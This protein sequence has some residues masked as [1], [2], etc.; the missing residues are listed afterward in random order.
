MPAALIGTLAIPRKK[1]PLMILRQTV[2][3]ARFPWPQQRWP[4][5][6]CM[7]R[8]RNV[9]RDGEV[10]TAGAAATTAPVTIVVDR[11]M[12]KSETD[13]LTGAFKAG[14]PAALRKALVGVQAT[15][16]VQLGAGAATRRLTLERPTDKG[17]LLTIVTDQPLLFRR[18]PAGC[19]A[20][21][22]L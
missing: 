5:R 19:Q 14:G 13:R 22:R 8:G 17:R 4:C 3:T 20:Q 21:R 7:H 18:R 12:P 15:G 16:T 11:K 9:Y 10:K 2:L 6:R 1:R